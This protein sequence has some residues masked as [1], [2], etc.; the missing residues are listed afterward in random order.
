M[1]WRHDRAKR[2]GEIIVVKSNAV[3]DREIKSTATII[4]GAEGLD[5]NSRE[6]AIAFA[7]Y[8][9]IRWAR[10]HRESKTPSHIV[11]DAIEAYKRGL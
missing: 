1:R 9:A 3:L 11:R 6:A 7:V 4:N 8:H 2:H 5:L 10:G